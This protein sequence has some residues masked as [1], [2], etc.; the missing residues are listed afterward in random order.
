M[1]IKTV[2]KPVIKKR[3]FMYVQD[4][5]GEDLKQEVSRDSDKLQLDF[6]EDDLD[7]VNFNFK[8]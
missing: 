4:L 8:K 2:E 1:E 3:R 6:L 5:E 7:E